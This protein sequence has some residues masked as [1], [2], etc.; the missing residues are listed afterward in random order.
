[1]P[2]VIR[3]AGAVPFDG[4][5]SAATAF[6]ALALVRPAGSVAVSRD[7]RCAARLRDPEFTPAPKAG[8]VLV[9]DPAFPPPPLDSGVAIRRS[10]SSGISYSVP[11]GLSGSTITSPL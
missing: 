8:G 2:P 5:V 9:A 4:S 7:R 10:E 1:M 3:L 6:V 11:A